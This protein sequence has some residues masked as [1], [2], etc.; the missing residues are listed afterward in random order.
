MRTL[1]PCVCMLLAGVLAASQAMAATEACLQ[2]AVLQELGRPVEAGEAFRQCVELEPDNVF[3]MSQLGLALLRQGRFEAA[4]VWFERAAARESGDSFPLLWLGALELRENDEA[5]AAARFA[6]VLELEP[7]NADAH[8]FLGVIATGRGAPQQAVGHFEQA[9]RGGAGDPALQ[10]RLARAYVKLDMVDAAE[11]A[12]EQALRQAPQHG[13]ALLGLGWLHYNAGRHE[14][15]MELWRQAASSPDSARQA[16][17]SLAL[18]AN[19]LALAACARGEADQALALWRQALQADPGNRAARHY[20]DQQHGA[21][22]GG[23]CT[24]QGG[25]SP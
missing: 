12:Y 15:A 2:G 16:R 1:L 5:A 8:Y 9:G 24:A 11:S 21:A 22:L 7:G 18:A 14:Q 23:A 10:C 3:A 20:L 4:R 19:A 13:P 25:L 17:E 6:R